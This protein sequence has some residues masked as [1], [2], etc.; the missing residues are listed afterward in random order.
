MNIDS[1]DQTK[2]ILACIV[3]L[4]SIGGTAFG[5][6]AYFFRKWYKIEKEKTATREELDSH[7]KDIS[8]IKKG[9][10]SISQQ[11]EDVRRQIIEV[12]KEAG[13]LKIEVEKVRA[14]Q[15]RHA[16]KL[17]LLM[18]DNEVT[19]TE[20]RSAIKKAEKASEQVTGLHRDIM[21]AL[22]NSTIIPNGSRED[23]PVKRRTRTP[24]QT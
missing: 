15:E 24:K 7:D 3:A 23:E 12:S 10:T 2:T 5:I 13:V 9:S 4:L 17:D 18:I 21:K 19:R 6:M 22:G 14:S 20:A 1:L 11:L 16:G 8:D